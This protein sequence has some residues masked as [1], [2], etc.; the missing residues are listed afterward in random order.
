MFQTTNQYMIH[1]YVSNQ[2]VKTILEV[3]AIDPSDIRHFNHLRSGSANQP[4]KIDGS[5]VGIIGIIP[6]RVLEGKNLAGDMSIL[7]HV[8]MMMT[9]EPLE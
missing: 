1:V 8:M 4:D 6:E 3:Y 7:K 5:M 9:K 2:Y